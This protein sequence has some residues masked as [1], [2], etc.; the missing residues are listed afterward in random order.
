MTM[1]R[2]VLWMLLILVSASFYE[3]V[4]SK[5]LRADS[6]LVE[7]YTIQEPSVSSDSGFAVDLLHFIVDPS[8]PRNMYRIYTPRAGKW[9]KNLASPP[10]RLCNILRIMNKRETADKV[11]IRLEVEKPFFLVYIALSDYNAKRFFVT[12][13]DHEEFRFIEIEST[14]PFFA[15]EIMGIIFAYSHP[16]KF[17]RGGT[18]E[19]SVSS[20]SGAFRDKFTLVNLGEWDKTWKKI[21]KYFPQ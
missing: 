13:I 15:E 4:K 19:V 3:L 20:E 21:K 7:K 18:L 11:R 12:D 10:S 6:L 2:K 16:K 5:Q 17:S 9:P 14:E 1:I 8:P